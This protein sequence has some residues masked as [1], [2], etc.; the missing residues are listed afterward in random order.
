MLTTNAV[1]ELSTFSRGAL[2]KF[3]D[4]G[5][6]KT[7]PVHNGTGAGNSRMFTISQ[8]V[9]LQLAHRMHRAGCGRGLSRQAMVYISNLSAPALEKQIKSGK[10]VL[11][12]PPFP[13]QRPAA[14]PA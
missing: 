8:A 3:V 7:P 12:F 2:T 5:L 1:C 4:A 11:L 9:G 10:S 6:L 13:S 14:Q